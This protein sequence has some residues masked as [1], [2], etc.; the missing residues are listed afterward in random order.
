VAPAPP[1]VPQMFYRAT[2]TVVV[3]VRQIDKAGIAIGA[4]LAAGANQAGGI[5]FDVENHQ[6][7]E[8]QARAKAVVDAQHRAQELARL[9]NVKLGK[10]VSVSEGGGQEQGPQ[11]MFAAKAASFRSD[12][13]AVP[14][15]GGQIKVT[16]TVRVVYG[17]GRGGDED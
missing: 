17:I 4:A 11:P 9:S 15:E 7:L 1:P 2:N 10:V 5:E 14:V 8:D 3:T 6:P 13:G 16:Y 12:G